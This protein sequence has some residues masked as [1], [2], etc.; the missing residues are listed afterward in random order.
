[1][2]AEDWKKLSLDDRIKWVRTRIV[3]SVDDAWKIVDNIDQLVK[4][5]KSHEFSV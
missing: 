4:T 2:K 1:M 3:V 5:A